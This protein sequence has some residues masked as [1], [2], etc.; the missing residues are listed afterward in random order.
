[1][2]KYLVVLICVGALVY[3]QDDDTT[4]P[5]P[6]TTTPEPEPETTTPAPEPETT[7]PEPTTIEPVTCPPYDPNNNTPTYLPDPVYCGIF[8][9][10]AA[11]VAYKFEC[12]GGTYF[13]ATT[14]RCDWN[15]DCGDKTTTLTP[16]TTTSS[17]T[18]GPQD[19]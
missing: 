13:N 4:V 1:M 2:F 5:E 14:S 12:A 11:G 6:E 9:E 10:C 19:I 7:T 15:V 8:Y 16:P 17:T 3:C 18:E